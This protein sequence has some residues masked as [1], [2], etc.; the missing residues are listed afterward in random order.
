M[1]SE[2]VSSSARAEEPAGTGVLLAVAAAVAAAI[3]GWSSIL[4]DS[5][6]DTWHDAVR[7]HVKESAGAVEDIRFVY[8]EEALTALQVSEA[9][10]L[11]E[12]YRRAAEAA[13]GLAREL[14]LLEASGQEEAA[15]AMEAGSEIA[16]D[17]RYQEGDGFNLVLRLA[18]NREEMPELLALDPDA[19]EAEGS[20]LSAKA[21][22]LLLCTVPVTAAFLSGA[23]VYGFPR[24]RRSLL[25]TGFVL[26]G[27][28][29]AAAIAVG[30]LV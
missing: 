14:L 30:A 25:V 22:L 20:R 12:E 5:G 28:G 21:S 13:T 19:T 27:L 9:R 23:L 3:G 26:A 29:G 8:E 10:I 17:P 18:D 24:W 6:S 15:G 7:E 11:A 16:G 4:A 2:P 1:G